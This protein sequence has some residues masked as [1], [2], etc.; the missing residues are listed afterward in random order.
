MAVLR[1]RVERRWPKANY[2]IGILYVNGKRFCETLEDRVR[3]LSREA[4][5][6]GQTAI[7]AGTYTIDMYSISP[8]F[9]NKVWG[10]LYGGI[11]PRLQSVPHFDGVLI[12]PG[13][14]AADTEG[15]I[16]VGRNT[17]VGK[18]TSSQDTY[19]KLMDQYLMPARYGH[20]R[21]ILEII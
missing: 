17:E 9:R 14:T 21:I 4:K 11:V 19:R 8:K 1:L 13:N 2:T 15:C 16:L 20:D 10:K 3:D 7:P 12:H 6:P 18:V 5:V